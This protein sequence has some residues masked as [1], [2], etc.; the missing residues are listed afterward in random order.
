MTEET[1]ALIRYRL[2]RACETLEEAEILL[3]KKHVNTYVNRLYYACFYAVSALLLIKSLSSAKHSGVR[4]LFH[5]NFVKPGIVAVELGE[6]YDKLY[7]NR[8]KGDYAD[9]VQFN[10]DDVRPWRE[11]ARR[12]VEI[13]AGII[14]P[15]ITK[16]PPC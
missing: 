9:F 4:A 15:A 6:L 5:Q 16:E 1:Q 2:E 11:E 3:E 10:E 8:Q 7:R 14:D 12:F 13:I